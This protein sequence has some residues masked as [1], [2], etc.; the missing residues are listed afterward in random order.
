MTPTQ[1]GAAALESRLYA[2]CCWGGTLDVHDSELA[3]D[4]RKEIETR[5]AR[6]ETTETVQADF[7]ARYGERVLAARSD[8]PIAAMGL[9]VL[10]L[11]GLVGVL[12]AARLR[13]WTRPAQV[14]RPTSAAPDAL[15][16]RVDAELA[17]MD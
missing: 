16:A 9:F 13:R 17:E 12:L 1:P 2:P 14:P 4:L 5:L 8:R 15:D 10:A 11:V 7:V 6:G 3:R